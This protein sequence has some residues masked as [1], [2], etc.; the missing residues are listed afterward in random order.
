MT[1]A[2]IWAW[3]AMLV[4]TA[5]TMLFNARF[6]WSLGAT[7]LDRAGLAAFSV[8]VD[9]LKCSLLVL[10]ADAWRKRAITRATTLFLLFWPC[11]AYSLTAGVGF[12][13]ST[14]DATTGVRQGT[15]DTHQRA[16]SA[17]D[18]TSASLK[19]AEGAA[20]Y[21]QTAACTQPKSK[22]QR[23]F[24]DG[25]ASLRDEQAAAAQKLDQGTTGSADPQAKMFGA[26]L[27]LS[28]E[29]IAFGLALLPAVL[30]E[31]LS[32]FGFYGLVGSAAPATASNKPAEAVPEVGEPPK[33]VLP[34]ET[35]PNTSEHSPPLKA[36][37]ASA[38][39]FPPPRFRPPL[40]API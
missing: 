25:V 23:E 20:N 15:A 17:Y 11:L 8:A 24:C 34:A 37:P 19:I 10:A 32:A 18:R 6:G 39:T 29:Q 2:S 38:S 30:A 7:D 31:L 21:S 22:L 13:A 33:H 14:R 4:V 36:R 9:A 28:A 26:I 5:C 27:G 3:I 35:P 1:V 12:V 16:Q 40:N